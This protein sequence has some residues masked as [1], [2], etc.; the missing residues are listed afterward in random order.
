VNSLFPVQAQKPDLQREYD[1]IAAVLGGEAERFAD[2]IAPYERRVYV[3]AFSILRSEADAEEVA[4]EAFLKAFRH[5]KTFRFESRFSTWLLRIVFN[6]A[7][8]RL[9][10]RNGIQMES[11]SEHEDSGYEPLQL[12]SWDEIPSDALERK[13]LRD[14]LE[15]ALATVPEKYR[16]V[17]VLRDVEGFSIAEA[18]S[19]LGVSESAVKVRL[20]RARMKMRD[21]LVRRLRSYFAPGKGGP[22]CGRS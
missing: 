12:A 3:A 14:E 2:L 4:Q 18:A 6:E 20:F 1:L 21:L 10:R 16:E 8:M 7:R 11:L 19:I 13:E 9:R 17:L 5:L 15:R 22:S